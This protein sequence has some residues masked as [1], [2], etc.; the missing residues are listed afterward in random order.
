MLLKNSSTT[1]TDIPIEVLQNEEDIEKE[2]N[3]CPPVTVDV[4]EVINN[5]MNHLNYVF[6]KNILYYLMYRV[7]ALKNFSLKLYYIL[8]VV[9][10]I[11]NNIYTTLPT[12]HKN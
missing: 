9:L 10:T 2:N 5:S 11:Y 8:Y 4:D 7:E 1:T 12:I 3:A 6:F